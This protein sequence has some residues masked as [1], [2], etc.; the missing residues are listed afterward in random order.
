MTNNSPAG[1]ILAA[2]K[3]TRMKSELPKC[4]FPVCGLPMA[5]HIGRAMRKAG[6]EKIVVV[7]GHGRE[8]L[9]SALG[10][11]YEYAIQH[12]QKGTGDAALSASE[13]LKG[14]EGPVLIAAGDTPLMTSDVFETLLHTHKDTNAGMTVATCTVANPHGY[15]R[16]LRSPDGDVQRIVEHKDASSDEKL[17]NEINSA[18]YCVDGR[19]L[20]ALL[21]QLTNDNSQGEYY[22]PDLIA[23]VQ[24]V[25][26]RTVACLIED[27]SFLLGVNDRWQLAE[28]SQIMGRR[29]LR[30]L[31]VSGVTF[32]DPDS[33]YIGPDV[34]V[35]QD[36]VI[37]PMTVIE[38]KSKIGQSC[39]IGPSSRIKNSEIGDR[40]SILMSNLD[41]VRVGNGVTCG[42][43][44]NL[45]PGS[46]IGDN[47]KIG[48]FVETK[49]SL[50]QTGAKVSHLSYIGDAE[51][52]EDANIGAGTITCN[53]DGFLKHRT[54]IGAN[55][56]VGS[57]STLVAP[58]SIG[59]GAIIAA[60]SVITSDVP[61]DSLGLGRSRQEV[62]SDWA[63]AFRAKKLSEKAERRNNKCD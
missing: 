23:L 32:I 20:F 5:D 61:T 22:L 13:N 53:Y 17:V 37:H 3:G 19:L 26:R 21:P 8:A 57:N 27:E 14:F 9:I 25:N 24:K 16:V 58:I 42:P 46:V 38:G 4:V 35:G 12:E 47:A 29:I 39:E 55:A 62:K 43:F 7:V 54:K 45:R 56:F 10:Q 63:P 51:V 36:C 2:G 28:A 11:S 34:S 60:G 18:N 41:Q 1:I 15:G 31:A 30:E 49:N 40:S 44:A 59:N 52:G 33:T 6:V 48:N 50:I